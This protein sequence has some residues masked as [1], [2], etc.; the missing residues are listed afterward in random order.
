MKKKDQLNHPVSELYHE[1]KQ[2]TPILFPYNVYP[3]TIP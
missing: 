1:T 2:H 3:C